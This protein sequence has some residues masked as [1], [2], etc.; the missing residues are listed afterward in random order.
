[1]S[2][3][4]EWVVATGEQVSLC[5]FGWQSLVPRWQAGPDPD[6]TLTIGTTR[7]VILSS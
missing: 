4:L 2:K 6:L 3:E 5:N 7:P 1:M